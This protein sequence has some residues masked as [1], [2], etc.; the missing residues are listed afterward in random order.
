MIDNKKLLQQANPVFKMLSTS[1]F[2]FFGLGSHLS[3]HFE[4][5]E[6]SSTVCTQCCALVRDNRDGWRL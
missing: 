6:S 4:I 1:G 2:G 5:I 3:L